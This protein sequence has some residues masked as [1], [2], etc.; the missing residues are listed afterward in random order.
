[1]DETLLQLSS[2][3]IRE[4][5]FQG[6]A[7]VEYKQSNHGVPVLMEINGRPWGSM[8][9]P[10]ASGIDYPRYLIDWCLTGTL[11]PKYLQYKRQVTCR[12]AVGELSH[13]MNLRKGKPAFWQGDYPNFWSTLFKVAIPWYPG[14]HY[15]EL[16]FSDWRPGVAEVAQWFRIRFTR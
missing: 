1:V 16:W 2:Q 7:M 3:L 11:P 13:L 10:I 15:D 14:M 4:I 12:R 9:L 5:G 8:A 6:I